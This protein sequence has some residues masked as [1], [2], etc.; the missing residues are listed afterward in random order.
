MPAH[1]AE[2]SLGMTK[3]HASAVEERMLSVWQR[4][5]ELND[6][7]LTLAVTGVCIALRQAGSALAAAHGVSF[8]DIVPLSG[9]KPPPG[10]S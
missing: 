10:G 6:P 5:Q 7:Q 4:S 8:S 3:A 2:I 1:D 9:A